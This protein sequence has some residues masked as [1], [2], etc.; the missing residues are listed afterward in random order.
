[1]GYRRHANFAVEE[2]FLVHRF[3]LPLILLVLF[4]AIAF[5]PGAARPSATAIELTGSVGPGFTISLRDASGNIVGHLDP[6]TYHITVH[7]LSDPA[8]GIVHNF[9]LQGPG[10][11]N[12]ATTA[13]PGTTTWDVTFVD[14]TYTYLCDFHPTQMRHTFTAGNAPP[15]PLVTKLVGKVAR[16]SITLKRGSALVKSLRHGKFVI[17]VN[18][19]STKDNFHLKGPGISKKTS[20]AKRGKVTWKV[21]FR[22]GKY[23]YFSDAHRKLKRAFS[24]K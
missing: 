13:D 8:T 21:T 7:N 18:D 24:V 22:A 9:H 15:P 10:G 14:G 2:G 6:G 20:V 11:V 4:S 17:A 1:M 12:L 16:N 19:A 23:T 5:A 3:R